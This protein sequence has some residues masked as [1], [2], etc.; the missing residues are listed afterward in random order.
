M[1]DAEKHLW[2]KIRRKQLGFK[3]HRQSSIGPYI[4]DF[5][6][7]KQQMIIELDGQHH[8]KTKD[9]DQYRSDFFKALN[10]RVIRFWNS[11][12]LNSTDEVVFEIKK[13]FNFSPSRLE[14]ARGS[15]K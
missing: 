3:F 11:D 9:Y 14:G 1:T 5:Y 15:I 10:I 6:C 2:S 13:M 4:V 12:V 8:K 7:P